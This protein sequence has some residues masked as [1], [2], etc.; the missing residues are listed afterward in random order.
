MF[1]K[2]DPNINRQG[3]KPGTQNE[4]TKRMKE[5]FA[6]LIEGNLDRMTEWLDQIA[7]QDPKSAM[8]IIIRLSERFVPKLSQQQL[9]DADGG[10]LFKNIQF[11][12]GE[13]P[14][15]EE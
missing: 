7:E 2:G 10:D 6:F 13:E 5:S 12:F 4:Q 3:K 1:S 11:R 8:D 9:T 14:K 15:S